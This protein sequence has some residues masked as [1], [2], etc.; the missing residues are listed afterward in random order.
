M[1]DSFGFDKRAVGADHEPGAHV[2]AA[3]GVDVPHLFGFVPHRGRHGGL[4]HR[5]VVQ[6]VALRDQLAVRED[7]RRA[8]VVMFRH[9]AHFIE[10]RQIVVRH[11]VARRTGIAVPVPRAAHICAAFDDANARNT[12]LA[13]PRR[14]QQ[15][16]EAAADEQHF[17]RVANRIA[18]LNGSAVRIHAVLGAFAVEIRGELLSALGPVREP[19]IAL[20]RELAFDLVV[21]GVRVARSAHGGIRF[22]C[23][24]SPERY[25]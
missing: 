1:R 6:V 22:E 24:L 12:V 20:L 10:Q 25:E 13:Q 19:Q 4:E 15:R 3:I 7:L 23:D 14:R 17:H 9:V 8:R 21:I 2:I 5:E 18:R 11:H 16:R